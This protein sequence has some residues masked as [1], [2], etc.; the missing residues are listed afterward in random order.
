M[1]DVRARTFGGTAVCDWLDEMQSD[2]TELLPG[3]VVLEFSGNAL[4]SCMRDEQG[5]PLQGDAY[6]EKYRRDAR[7]AMRI[8]AETDTR[9]I[10]AGAPISRRDVEERNP[11]AGRL[12]ALYASLAAIGDVGYVDAGDAV[13]DRGRWTATLA[14]LA[15]EPCSGGTGGSAVNPVRA[16]DGM[17][18]CPAAPE[19]V[20]GVTGECP[21]WSS[22]AYRFGRAMARAV[23][24]RPAGAS[25][26]VV[27]A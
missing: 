8:F 12:N 7:E 23:V 1:H 5:A 14:C 27:A 11:D 26:G 3:T 22:G 20:N 17:H 21:V 19:A 15:S 2:A 4:T 6:F 10:F 16:P 18:F 24:A 25:S 13:L 9:V